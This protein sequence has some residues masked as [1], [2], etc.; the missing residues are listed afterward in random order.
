[1]NTFKYNTDK[2]SVSAHNIKGNNI[3]ILIVPSDADQ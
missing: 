2:S 3:K 1:M